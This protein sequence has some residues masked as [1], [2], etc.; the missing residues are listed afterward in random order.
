MGDW[1]LCRIF[2]HGEKTVEMCNQLLDE[3]VERGYIHIRRE[4]PE[5]SIKYHVAKRLREL[6]VL[7][8]WTIENCSLDRIHRVYVADRKRMAK[9]RLEFDQL[10][11]PWPLCIE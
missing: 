5:K 7:M 3:L 10:D 1:V 8:R 2:F 9:L 11:R 6:G 4:D